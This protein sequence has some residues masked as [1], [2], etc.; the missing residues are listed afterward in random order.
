MQNPVT[1]GRLQLAS[2]AGADVLPS[3]VRSQLFAVKVPPP[4]LTARNTRRA[5]ES[6]PR[7][8]TL[9]YLVLRK[10]RTRVDSHRTVRLRLH[11]CYIYD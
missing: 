7:A 4:G 1:P 8:C 3:C 2:K 10:T 6:G 11:Y 5:T 9:D